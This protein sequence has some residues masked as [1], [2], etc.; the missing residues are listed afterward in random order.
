MYGL[1]SGVSAIRV[2][3]AELRIW[4]EWAEGLG[5]TT[6]GVGFGVQRFGVQFL[7]P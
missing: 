2:F 5:F 3:W 7:K 6:W 4:T 1:G